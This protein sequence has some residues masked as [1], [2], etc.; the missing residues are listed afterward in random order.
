ME[1]KVKVVIGDRLGK[2]QQVAKGVEAAGGIPI[3]IP[4]VGADMKVGDFMHTEGADFGICFC[5]SG[6][7]GAL[8]AKTKYQYPVEYS[9][10]SVEAGVRALQDGKKVIGFGFMD[11]EE[12]GRRLTQAYMKRIGG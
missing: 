2:G 1:R 3:L 10:R 12:L 9:L 4:G 8:T 6:G 11:T 5:G 7:A